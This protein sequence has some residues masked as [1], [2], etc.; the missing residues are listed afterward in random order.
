[1]PIDR[2]A[3]LLD[4]FGSALGGMRVDVEGEATDNSR[5]HRT[6]QIAADDNHGPEIPCMAAL[7]LTLRLLRDGRLPAGASVC[8]GMLRLDEFLPEFERWGM[9]AG[10]ETFAAG[11]RS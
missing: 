3:R 10:T 5:M 9:R 6:W 2:A 1:M 7:L 8:M 11:G 4:R